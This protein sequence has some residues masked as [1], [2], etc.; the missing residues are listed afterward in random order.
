MKAL[1]NS[2]EDNKTLFKPRFRAYQAPVLRKKNIAKQ[3]S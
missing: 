3:H 2:F 1:Q